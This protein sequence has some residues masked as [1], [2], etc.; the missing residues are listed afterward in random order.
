MLSYNGEVSELNPLNSNIG[1]KLSRKI[2]LWFH[3]ITSDQRIK[4]VKLAPFGAKFEHWTRTSLKLTRK[5]LCDSMREISELNLLKF[6]HQAETGS[7]K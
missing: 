3:T 5:S 4:P 6:Q 7:K 2:S 1:L